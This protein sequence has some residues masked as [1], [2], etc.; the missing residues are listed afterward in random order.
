MNPVVA[1]NCWDWLADFLAG[2]HSS[3]GVN[4]V[5]ASA[6]VIGCLAPDHGSAVN[7]R[8]IMSPNPVLPISFLI[9]I[10]TSQ[11]AAEEIAWL[12]LAKSRG[13]VVG[14]DGLVMTEA[15]KP[16]KDR[17]YREVKEPIRSLY[18]EVKR[19]GRYRLMAHGVFD[20][21]IEE[22]T[23]YTVRP[24]SVSGVQVAQS[25]ILPHRNSKRWVEFGHFNLQPGCY[26][27]RSSE[28]SPKAGVTAMRIEPKPKSSGPSL[29][30]GDPLAG[31]E[32][33]GEDDEMEEEEEDDDEDL[34]ELEDAS[35]ARRP[36][37]SPVGL[38][39]FAEV[40]TGPFRPR[41]IRKWGKLEVLGEL[42]GARVTQ[43]VSVDGGKSWQ[44]SS[45]PDLSS[46]ST[47]Q[48]VQVRLT[49]HPKGDEP[50]SLNGIRLSFEREEEKVSSLKGENCRFDFTPRGELV[51]MH[52]QDRCIGDIPAPDLFEI[53]LRA[54]KGQ[55][56]SFTAKSFT[57]ED[58][59]QEP[60]RM[61]LRFRHAEPAI[62]AEVEVRNGKD[63]LSFWTLTVKNQGPH[64]TDC[65]RFPT[66][67]PLWLHAGL[68]QPPRALAP[69]SLWHAGSG[70]SFPGRMSM[71][72]SCW[73]GE[74]ASL[75]LASLDPTYTQVDFSLPL[76]QGLAGIS[77]V[78][79]R[80]IAPGETFRFPYAVGLYR[81][82]W[83]R[84]ADWYRELSR[85]FIKKPQH[86]R[87]AKYAD[88]WFLGTAEDLCYG[89]RSVTSFPD[90]RWIGFTY[91]QTW[92][93]GDGE[94]VGDFGY[95]SPTL[96]APEQHRLDAKRMA[97]HDGHFGYY[98]QD[99]EFVLDY[100][101]SETHIGNTLKKLFPPW[102]FFPTKDWF[103]ANSIRYSGGSP[104][105]WAGN[106][107]SYKVTE[108][109]HMC[110]GADGW[111]KYI[112]DAVRSNVEHYGCST[113]Y[114]DQL[115]CTVQQCW[116][117]KHAHGEQYGLHGPNSVRVAREVVEACRELNPD[118][119]LAA[120]GM[121]CLSGQYVN[122]HL[123]SSRPYRDHG[124]EFLYTFPD[125]L[126][127][128]GTANGCYQWTGLPMDEHLR[129]LYLFHRYDF[130]EF[131][132]LM[133]E[134]ILLRQR[135]RDWMY[136]AR[137]MDDVGL[138]CE[139]EKVR[140]KW[141]LREE[142]GTAGVL[143]NF[144][145]GE[146][147]I[148]PKIELKIPGLLSSESRTFLYLEG[149][150]VQPLKPE[151]G[152]GQVRYS[153]PE[154]P[155]TVGTI[156]SVSKCREQ[157][158]LRPF[159]Y[160]ALRAGPDQLIV[161]ATNVGPEALSGTWRVECDDVVP[162]VKR[163]GEFTVGSGKV[164]GLALRLTDLWKLQ[165][166]DDVRVIFAAAD[167]KLSW[168]C[169]AIIA[170]PLVNGSFEVDSNQTGCPDN[171]WSR[172]NAIVHHVI[173][174]S[175]D[176]LGYDHLAKLDEASPAEGAR[177]IRL[178]PTVKYRLI[179]GEEARKHATYV[180]AN[181]IEGDEANLYKTWSFGTSQMLIVK[182]S[183]TY[184]IGYRA[185]CEGSRT[186][187]RVSC[188]FAPNTEISDRTGLAKWRDEV[189]TVRTP[190]HMGKYPVL[191]FYGSSKTAA[192][193]RIWID[194]VRVLSASPQAE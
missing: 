97:K 33:D 184:R 146:D 141:F 64:P 107:S 62:E 174:Y 42:R 99:Q 96:G 38:P 183:T 39:N 70:G 2:S 155:K 23:R 3:T 22:K 142:E 30:G 118:F 81:G 119:A 27:L 61:L 50:P 106:I 190:R 84:A 172:S 93:T 151:F 166:R 15:Y 31:G 128:R 37:N 75:F 95:C 54:P 36:A 123:A 98:I 92:Y 114:I 120:E 105:R 17:I 80:V 57:L 173:R 48:G 45:G 193:N 152:D 159:C 167:G 100:A 121:S 186:E 137:F 138:T 189:L 79:R 8:G 77:T 191:S 41:N 169:A 83:H 74:N 116:D 145:A 136:E 25:R 194:D 44:G 9:C 111:R 91:C 164:F 109:R 192:G 122:F 148:S 110:L 153:L 60:G 88:G 47:E 72:W 19:P 126:I 132:P 177:S 68:H 90:A 188:A 162:L 11:V 24:F 182:P 165:A 134:I 156:L 18:F 171:W 14:A 112:V 144:K 143:I 135:I 55:P 46:L 94:F 21:K 26:Q 7:E 130:C 73:Q 66:F 43:Q 12:P 6:P 67:R 157:E 4:P 178:D 140:A 131:S 76:E 163:T 170:P 35:E 58:S 51:A 187:G 104:R 154:L 82:D 49:V 52:F 89:R 16:V 40:V 176:L 32:K 117:R 175:D 78:S 133:R 161:G 179:R 147:G 160:Q 85:P 108:Q 103:E 181:E 59:S 29:S 28:L 65:V 1:G 13:F 168:E 102:T 56:S 129:D 87:W 149:G 125:S 20:K 185:R 63:G 158:A 127:F 150:D 115:S 101:L 34:D 139:S 5:V 180:E 10:F 53:R 124:K 86:P 69:E 113:Q 71:G